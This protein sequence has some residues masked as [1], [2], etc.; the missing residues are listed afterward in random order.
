MRNKLFLAIA[1]IAV[2]TNGSVAQT[3]PTWSGDIANIIYNNCT[4]CHRYGG[5]APFPLSDFTSVS[6][7]SASIVQQVTSK[8]MPPWK[9]DPN[10]RHF[11]GEKYLSQAQIT[12]IENWVNAG[13]PFG[14]IANEPPL[15][16][17]VN[18]SVLQS[19]DQTI[20]T[21]NYTIN[22]AIDVY[23]T[24]VI[25][26]NNTQ[27]KYLN[28]VEFL[29]GNG[30]AVHHIILFQDST[31][32]SNNLD[33]ADPEPGFASNG[34]MQT[35]AGASY[36]ALWAPGAGVYQLPHNMGIR[37]KPGTDFLVEVHYAPNNLGQTDSSTINIKY[38]TEPNIREVF[39]DPF[40]DWNFPSIVNGPLA[41]PANQTK[42]VKQRFTNSQDISVISVFPHMHK[43]G[44]SYKIYTTNFSN[45][46][47]TK[48]LFIP[49]W[50]FHWQGFY[51][52]QKIQKFA[53]NQRLWGE[54]FYDNT[55]NNEDNPSSPPINV[56]AGEH[57]TDEMMVTFLAYTN[58]AVGDEEIVLDS[59]LF[60]AINEK[61]INI[62]VS[63]Y[64]NPC[65]DV[66][67]I[68]TPNS[69]NSKTVYKIVDVFG[70]VVNTGTLNNKN[71][72]T[73]ALISGIYIVILNDEN[74]KIAKLRFVKN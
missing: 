4:S 11:K 71:I 18:G 14:N 64:P 28:T 3:T 29:P 22:S 13:K 32:V 65:K 59:N 5:I 34:T 73:T 43:I 31:N 42:T 7:N 58:Y 26:A 69:F 15:P 53:A 61:E 40:M 12:K 16:T 68:N 2:S 8:K 30:A 62:S 50:N 52:F 24:Y 72:N 55:T 60:A 39:V 38:T 44:K 9:P 49:D 56:V 6:N 41:I 35:S 54:A 36:V 21:P 19:I 57:T 48:Y 63:I 10:Y 27:D 20:N 17:F 23:R 37:I 33:I 46:D 45:A 51:T 66:L 47:T 25:H 1:V 74:N 70:S 67:N